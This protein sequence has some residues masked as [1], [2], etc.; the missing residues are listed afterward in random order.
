MQWGLTPERRVW[1]EQ[2]G[3]RWRKIKL[4]FWFSV[5]DL[6]LMCEIK[7]TN[8]PDFPGGPVVKNWPWNAGD[9]GLVPCL[10]RSHMPWSN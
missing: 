6:H 4:H 9:T 1:A 10:G 7:K 8:P 2:R 3:R 5:A